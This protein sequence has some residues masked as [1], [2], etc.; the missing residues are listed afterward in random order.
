MKSKIAR[1]TLIGVF[2]VMICATLVVSAGLLTYFGEVDADINAKQLI[3]LNNG[4]G[5]NTIERSFNLVGGNCETRSFTLQNQDDEDEM[6]IFETAIDGHGKGPDG[7]TVEYIFHMPNWIPATEM[8]DDGGPF[9]SESTEGLVIDIATGVTLNDL[10]AG[11]GFQYTYEVKDGGD[12]DGA[13][14]IVAKITI[15]D[16]SHVVLY[17]GWGDRTGEHT[18]TFSDDTAWDTGGNNVVDFTV[19]NADLTGGAQWSNGGSYPAWTDTK[20]LS[21]CPVDGDEVVTRIAFMTQGANTGQIDELQSVELPVDYTS[22]VSETGSYFEF[23][24]P[25][26]TVIDFDIKYCLNR[27]IDPGLYTVTTTIR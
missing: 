20:A 27:L 3:R 13:A 4:D 8:E 19:Y 24:T 18:L 22:D 1:K 7:F 9:G 21:G 25:G 26:G 15:D 12:Y 10:F 6:A 2:A 14:P 16:G 23:T 17:P 5:E 11:D